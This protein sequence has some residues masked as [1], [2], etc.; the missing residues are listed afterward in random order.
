[1]LFVGV[2]GRKEGP[3]REE[4]GPQK[5]GLR[6]TRKHDLQSP[7]VKLFPTGSPGRRPPSL[8]G[9]PVDRNET[10]TRL[11]SEKG[12]MR[13]IFSSVQDGRSHKGVTTT[14]GVFVRPN[15]RS[16]GLDPV[17]VLGGVTPRETKVSPALGLRS[18]IILHKFT[19]GSFWRSPDPR[20]PPKLPYFISVVRG[21]RDSCTRVCVLDH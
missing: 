8:T 16:H 6:R 5:E 9:D 4:R 3:R 21:P 14:V 18:G 11:P 10:W 20:G 1:M 7:H 13:G 17:G 12:S 15:K 2:G 19:P